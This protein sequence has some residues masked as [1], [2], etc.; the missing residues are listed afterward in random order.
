MGIIKTSKK[1]KI[2]IIIQARMGATRL[3]GKM[4]KKIGGKTV[5]DHVIDR[6]KKVKGCDTLILATTNSKSDNVLERIGKKANILVYRGSERDVLDR[7]FQA[8][9][10]HGLNVVVRITGD[11]PFLD[12]G[13]TGDTIKAYLNGRYDYVSNCHPPSLP[14]G[15]DAEVCSFKALKKIWKDAKL[16]IEREHVFPY[17]LSNP[18]KFKIFNVSYDRDL[19]HLRL[20]LDE[21]ADLVLLRK[22]Y[23]KLYKENSNFGLKEITRLFETKPELIDINR[24]VVAKNISRW[25]INEKI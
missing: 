12:V 18:N 13:F 2:G 20:T 23:K 11:C 6:I 17:I 14:D 3:P 5:L 16:P 9:K 8:A 22:V 21:Q 19:S 25:K 24:N 7:Y 10:L 15:L 1:N 4:T